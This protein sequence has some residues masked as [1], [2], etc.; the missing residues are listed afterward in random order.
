M[1][2][3][4]GDGSQTIN[5]VSV[6]GSGVTSQVSFSAFGLTLTFNDNLTSGAGT[7]GFV[8]GEASGNSTFQVGAED[9]SNNRIDVSIGDVTAATLGLSA[10]K[11]DNATEAQTFLGTVDSAIS[12]LADA[13][14]DVGAAQNRL[15]YSYANLSVTIENVQAAESVMRDVDMASEM[16][17]FTKNQ[18]LLQA[19][20]AM[21][22]QANMAPQSVLSLFG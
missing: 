2:I 20:T 6:P 15:Q 4:T 22:A 5:D 21:L 14:G 16:T 8:E 3:T 7:A 17:T 12:T 19:G 9:N 1:T 18:I 10:D 11:L 13:R